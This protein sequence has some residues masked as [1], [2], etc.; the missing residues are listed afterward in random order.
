METRYVKYANPNKNWFA[1]LL[2]KARGNRTMKKFAEDCDVNPSTFSRIYNKANKGAS[3]EEL[4]RIIAENAAPESGVTLD[5]LMEA[6]GYL[7]DGSRMAARVLQEKTEQE[8]VTILT[9][10]LKKIP[11]LEFYREPAQ[12]KIGKSMSIRPDAMAD[13]VWL[14]EKY[15]VWLFD[16]FTPI[17]VLANS[18]GKFDDRHF[19][20]TVA[21]RVQERLGRYLASFCMQDEETRIAR[22]SMVLC[23]EQIYSLVLDHFGK[24]KTDDSISFILLDIDNMHVEEEFVLAH[25]N[26]EKGQSIINK[27]KVPRES[28]INEDDMDDLIWDDEE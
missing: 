3:S 4:I 8:C 10:S 27:Y 17:S 12:F 6:N 19:S 5:D 22:I 16:V 24:Y 14:D 21:R 25:R 20:F 15:G 7:P 11:G 1:E 18:P 13:N 2:D 28:I 9:Q 23:D 26:G